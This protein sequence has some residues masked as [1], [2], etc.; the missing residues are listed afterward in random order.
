MQYNVGVPFRSR[1]PHMLK[2]QLNHIPY[3]EQVLNS[4]KFKLTLDET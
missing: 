3:A 2:L 4:L 1:F